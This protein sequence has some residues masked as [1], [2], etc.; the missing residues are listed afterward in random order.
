MEIFKVFQPQL[1]YGNEI[2]E[3]IKLFIDDYSINEEDLA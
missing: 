2:K 3:L 1:H